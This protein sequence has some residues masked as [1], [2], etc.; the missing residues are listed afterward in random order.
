MIFIEVDIETLYNLLPS[1][2]PSVR[3]GSYGQIL[4]NYTFTVRNSLA[5]VYVKGPFCEGG[6]S[7]HKL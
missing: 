3:V 1:H 2:L 6:V 4:N 7:G 5:F